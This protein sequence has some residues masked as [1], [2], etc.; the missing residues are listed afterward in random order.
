MPHVL[1]LSKVYNPESGWYCGELHTHSSHSDGFDSPF[2]L[3]AEAKIQ[4][5]D[6]LAITDHN[7]VD[8]LDKF[9]ESP[10]I[11]V[12]PGM[13]IT[14][15]NGHFNVF[16]IQGWLDWM[17][18]VCIGY[19]TIK[20]AGK[21]PTPTA[22]M[23]R[24]VSQGLI[25][26]INHPLRT[27]Y[28][29]RDNATELQYVHCLEIWNKPDWPDTMHSNPQAVALWTRWL[30]EGYRVTAVGGSDHHVS[31]PRP[32]EHILTERLGWPRNYIYAQELSGAAILAALRQRRVF[33]TMG[34]QVTFQ[35]EIGDTIFDIGAEVGEVSGLLKFKATISNS[36]TSAYAQIIKNGKVMLKIPV[37]T[38]Q[39]SFFYTDEAL[40]EHSDWYRLEV[41]DEEEQ[42]LAITNP[43]FVG[44]RRNP[45][46]QTYGEFF[47]EFA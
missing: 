8:I 26:S 27:P 19:L 35:A 32:G 17:E 21:Y 11:L 13:E 1:S 36:A 22:L 47:N 23:R 4:G 24:M 30:N 33:V 10:E 45:E 2:Q 20:L 7:R 6:F 18:N 46:R 25:T 44:P 12:I 14:L 16:G 37:K 3:V 38:G 29:W 28:E 15:Q 42:L 41:C 34:P 31:K 40:P 5:L 43:I 39:A 9:E